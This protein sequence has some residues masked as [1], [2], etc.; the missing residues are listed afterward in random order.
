[1]TLSFVLALTKNRPLWQKVASAIPD[2]LGKLLVWPAH[3]FG[4]GILCL[5]FSSKLGGTLCAAKPPVGYLKITNAILPLYFLLMV[6]IDSSQGKVCEGISKIL[7][8]VFAL[9]WFKM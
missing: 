1:M 5:N 4:K 6:I 8:E 9:N 3:F 2:I 7:L